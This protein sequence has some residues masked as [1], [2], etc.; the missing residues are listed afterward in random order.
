MTMGGF[1]DDIHIGT[2]IQWV[3]LDSIGYFIL[4]YR[5][6]KIANYLLAAP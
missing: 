2:H 3:P 4:F 5:G 1:L 6:M